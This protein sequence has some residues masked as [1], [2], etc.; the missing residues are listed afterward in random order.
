MS[1]NLVPFADIALPE[2]DDDLPVILGAAETVNRADTLATMITSRRE[3]RYWVA[4][5]RNRSITSLI[6]A[7]FSMNVSLLGI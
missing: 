4:A 5:R 7:S 2:I 1:Q 6:W 3:K